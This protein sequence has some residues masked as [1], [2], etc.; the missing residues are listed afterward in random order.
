MNAYGVEG[1]ARGDGLADILERVLDRGVVIA[2]DVSISLV[3]IEL[4]TIKLRLLIASVDK[5]Q[6]MGIDWWSADPTLSA[7]ARA[8]Q[9]ENDALRAQIARIEARLDAGLDAQASSSAQPV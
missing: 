2:G 4:V 9:A 6:E 3:G 7:S 1:A 5:A 8:L